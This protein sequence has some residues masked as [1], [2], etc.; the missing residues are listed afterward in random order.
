MGIEAAT[1]ASAA[2][3]KG[4]SGVAVGGA[5]GSGL[6]LGAILVMLAK[7]PRT[8]REWAISLISTAASGVGGGSAVM[9]YFGLYAPLTSG[10]SIENYLG[11]MQL[12]GTFLACSLP[13]WLLARVAFNTM[14]KLQDKTADDIYKDAKGLL[15]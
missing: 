5:I 11:L 8:E 9:L 6:T 13:G 10:V 2:A 3:I 7:K 4:A 1:A 14:T 15:P 12:G